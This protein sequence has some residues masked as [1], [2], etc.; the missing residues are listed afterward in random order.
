MDNLS[1]RFKE[2]GGCH[3]DPSCV[4]CCLDVHPF[5]C[6]GPIAFDGLTEGDLAD[7]E[8][9]F[10][11]HCARCHGIDGAGGEGSNLARSKL[12]HAADDEALIE[13]LSD[14]IPGTGMPGNLDAGRRS[15]DC[16]WPAYVRTLGRLEDE[17]MPGDPLRGA[18]IYQSSGGCPA[19]H[20]LA[21]MEPESVPSLRMSVIDAALTI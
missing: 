4:L 5:T 18:D 19:C 3:D 10:R 11:V 15:T 14:G 12:K 1:A 9:L 7:G 21:G 17:E 2:K 8:R 20:I 16:A 13:L 6:L